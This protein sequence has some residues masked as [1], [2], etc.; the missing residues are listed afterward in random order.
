MLATFLFVCD[1]KGDHQ[2]WLGTT[3]TN[4]HGIAAFDFA[5]VSG[6]DQLV[7]SNTHACLGTLDNQMTEFP[8]LVRVEVETSIGNWDHPSLLA[9]VSMAQAVQSLSVSPKVFM[10][11]PVNWNTVCGAIQDL[12]WQYHLVP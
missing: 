5:T 8:G 3:T 11:L 10:K 4:R 6:C 9:V 2:E 1:L 7:F 12:Y